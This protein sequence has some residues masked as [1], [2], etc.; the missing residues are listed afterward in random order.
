MD[1]YESLTEEEIKRVEDLAERLR[2]KGISY[3]WDIVRMAA[4]EW[5]DM[6]G[7]ADVDVYY[8]YDD[9]DVFTDICQ[10]NST[11]V[12]DDDVILLFTL[13][14]NWYRN[15]GPSGLESEFDGE[16]L[17]KIQEMKEEGYGDFE[18]LEK[19]GYDPREWIADWLAEECTKRIG[20]L[21]EFLIEYADIRRF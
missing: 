13:E 15:W 2:K 20:S 17:E 4:Y 18:I 5:Y 14:E 11:H 9:D 7:D 6:I 21:E 12:F 19:L 16:E 8:D 3:G 1:L 10:G